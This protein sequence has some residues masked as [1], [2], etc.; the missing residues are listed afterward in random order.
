M[1]PAGAGLLLAVPDGAAAGP[2]AAVRHVAAVG[3]LFA[4]PAEAA[5]EPRAA[6]RNV[7]AVGLPAAVRDAVQPGPLWRIGLQ[8]RRLATGQRQAGRQVGARLEALAL[9]LA[10]AP[11]VCLMPAC[12]RW[13]AVPR[14]RFAGGPHRDRPAEQ[15]PAVWRRRG[16]VPAAQHRPGER[17]GR[18]HLEQQHWEQQ[19][20]G[21][22]H[23]AQQDRDG[24]RA[25]APGRPG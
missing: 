5:A 22:Q 23:S 13:D 19:H 10:A 3:L 11:D 8:A 15:R 1:V 4:V 21:P 25:T 2:R 20:L 16:L 7:A 6:V 12:S 14:G 18:Q 17:P 24:R 9:P